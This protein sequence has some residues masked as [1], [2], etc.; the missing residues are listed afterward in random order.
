MKKT[1]KRLFIAA[2][3]AVLGILL[4]VSVASAADTNLTP[5]E[6]LGKLIF[7]DKNLSLNGNQSCASCHAPEEPDGR[8]HFGGQCPRRGL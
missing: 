8:G 7:F 1:G 4:V 5:E 6:Q 3:I 2:F